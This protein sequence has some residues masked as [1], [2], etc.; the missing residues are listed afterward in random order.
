MTPEAVTATT[1]AMTRPKQRQE[2]H[3]PL[4]FVRPSLFGRKGD[5]AGGLTFQVTAARVGAQVNGEPDSPPIDLDSL[6]PLMG[7]DL[8][9]KRGI[10]K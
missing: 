9:L 5:S 6:F 8:E 3:V 7:G 4:T 1:A 2:S 10:L